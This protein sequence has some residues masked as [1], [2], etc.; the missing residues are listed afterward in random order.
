[1]LFKKANLDQEN[2]GLD[3]FFIK[4]A[5]EMNKNIM[6]LETKEFQE[7]LLNKVFNSTPMN[8]TSKTD[9]NSDAYKYS[10]TTNSDI[11]NIFDRR[12]YFKLKKFEAMSWFLKN[13]VKFVVKKYSIES[14]IKKER[15]KM[16]AK[17][18]IFF[19]TRE[20]EMFKKNRKFTKK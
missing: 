20:E 4:K 8:K 3:L 6:E 17:K 5:K 18:D 7:D 16:G 11:F 12:M 9:I 14:N 13:C 10:K 15:I 2:L 19:D 1:M